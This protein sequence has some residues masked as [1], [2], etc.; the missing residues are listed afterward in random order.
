[1]SLLTACQRV[2]DEV[3]MPRPSVVASSLDQLARM[4]FALAN[5]EIEELSKSKDWPSLQSIGAIEDTVIGVSTYAV[6]AD[7]RKLITGTAYQSAQYRRIRGSLT[8]SQWQRRR[9]VAL[10]MLDGYGLRIFGNPR[11]IYLTPT[12]EIEET[13]VYEYMS[14][15]FVTDADGVPKPA[16]TVDTDET[17]VGEDLFRA[18]LKWRIKHAKGLEYSEDYNQAMLARERDYAAELALDEICVGGPR[19]LDSLDPGYVRDTGF[20]G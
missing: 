3:G 12:P 5:T 13:L 11:L 4:L 1:M 18:G 19:P 9:N 8:P 6:P 15:F 7:F 16:F 17:I 20:G 2:C 14:K 10:N